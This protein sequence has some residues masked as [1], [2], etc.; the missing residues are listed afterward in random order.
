MLGPFLLKTNWGCFAHK[1]VRC[2]CT[3]TTRENDTRAALRKRTQMASN[4]GKK[5]RG[6]ET[7]LLPRRAARAASSERTVG[8]PDAVSVAPNAAAINPRLT[9]T[10]RQCKQAA[11]P[12]DGSPPVVCCG[13]AAFVTNKWRLLLVRICLA[14]RYHTA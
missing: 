1:G 6:R 11:H 13:G 3:H 2:L 12:G 5:I 4:G 9:C 7:T 10:T 14:L 8:R